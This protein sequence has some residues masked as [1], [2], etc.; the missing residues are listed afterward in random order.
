MFFLALKETEP[1]LP[2]IYATLIRFDT[3][4]LKEGNFG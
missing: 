1:P 4:R 2:S 3:F